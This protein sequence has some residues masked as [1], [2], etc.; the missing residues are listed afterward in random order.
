MYL[1]VIMF[2]FPTA[3]T[4]LVN[5]W[6]FDSI[7]RSPILVTVFFT[8][9][10]LT[11]ICIIQNEK[12]NLNPWFFL[13]PNLFNNNF[14]K[15]INHTTAF[16]TARIEPYSCLKMTQV[17]PFHFFWKMLSI[18]NFYKIQCSSHYFV[19]YISYWTHGRLENWR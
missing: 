17:S 7:F 5:Y 11:P 19:C 3:R 15:K 4:K 10:H 16:I 6:K 8:N 1:Y 9:N 13:W 12:L 18:M 14:S 2:L